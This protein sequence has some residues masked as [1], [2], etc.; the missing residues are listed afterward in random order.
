MGQNILRRVCRREA[1]MRE[2]PFM[3]SHGNVLA[4]AALS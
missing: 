1:G 3:Q 2:K 4:A